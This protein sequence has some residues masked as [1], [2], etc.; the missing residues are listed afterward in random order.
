MESNREENIGFSKIPWLDSPCVSPYLLL[1]FFLSSS[2]VDEAPWGYD[3]IQAP[4]GLQGLTY[5]PSLSQSVLSFAPWDPGLCSI[6]NMIRFFLV[7]EPL[8]LPLPLSLAVGLS[9]F[10]IGL[11]SYLSGLTSKCYFL[12]EA[13]QDLLS[14][15]LLLSES[16]IYF[17]KLSLLV[18]PICCFVFH[19]P[20]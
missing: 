9:G 13:L 2:N 4:R 18:I 6:W 1:A 16:P 17:R 3:C 19:I 12:R 14:P 11:P 10:F 20:L 15:T 7:P 8:H 5:L